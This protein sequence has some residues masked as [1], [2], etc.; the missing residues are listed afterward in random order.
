MAFFAC[1]GGP[2]SDYTGEVQGL[3]RDLRVTDHEGATST[4]ADLSPLPFTVPCAATP[5]S[6]AGATC[7][8]TTT[9]NTLVPGV[10]VAGQRATWQ[11]GR[12]EMLDGG[13]DGDAEDSADNELLATQGLF[14]P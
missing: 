13:G 14:V 1:P 4:I 8:V 5:S 6:D 12:L 7:A 2:L 3:L 11:L 9:F 10:V